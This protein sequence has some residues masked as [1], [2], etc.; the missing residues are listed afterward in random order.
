[1]SRIVMLSVVLIA[2]L[3]M[4]SAC[5]LRNRDQGPPTVPTATSAPQT[6]EPTAEPPTAPTEGADTAGDEIQ[7]ELDQLDKDNQS[8]DTLDDLP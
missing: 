7:A 1:M 4:L 6:V 2:A 3:L 8:A 5:G